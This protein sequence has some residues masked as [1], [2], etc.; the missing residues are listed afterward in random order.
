MH[1][2]LTTIAD[3]LSPRFCSVCGHRLLAGEK[4]LCLNCLMELRLSPYCNGE[5]GNAL[6]RLFW[7]GL[8]IERTAALM[9]YDTN[10]NQRKLVLDMKFHNMPKTGFFIGQIM[11]RQLM[12]TDFFVGVDMIVPVPIPAT[13][14]LRRGYN[15]SEQLAR[16][17]SSITHIPIDNRSVRRKNY[18]THQ[19]RLSIAERENNVKGS[20]YLA[21]PQRLEGKHILMVD[22]VITTVR[23]LREMGREIATVPNTRLSVLALAV[24][25]NL[26]RNVMAINPQ[27]L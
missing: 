22:D 13:R 12:G 15:Q 9:V 2:L 10:S 18:K 4:G 1:S 25:K 11:A 19:A 5:A 17:I 3:L 20:F 26:L 27:D 8:P 23:T 7:Q 21:K 6:E 14:M 16:G 24:S